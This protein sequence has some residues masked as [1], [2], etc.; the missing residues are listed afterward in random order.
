MV[1]DS[2]IFRHPSL[3][4]TTSC[5]VFTQHSLLKIRK[6]WRIFIIIFA[7]RQCAARG[8]YLINVPR[9]KK[10]RGKPKTETYACTHR[11]Y[12]GGSGPRTFWPGSRLAAVDLRKIYAPTEHSLA[13]SVSKLSTALSVGYWDSNSHNQSI[14]QPQSTNRHISTLLI[15]YTVHSN[16]S[17]MLW[18]RPG[19]SARLWFQDFGNTGKG[20]RRAWVALLRVTLSWSAKHTVQQK[21]AHIVR[22]LFLIP[23]S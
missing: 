5:L 2:T 18:Y 23:P 10:K 4:S 3:H 19:K 7:T 17:C 12:Q 6:L 11:L 15:Q 22:S 9:K 20:C 14:N 1:S 16:R 21:R 13:T 8:W